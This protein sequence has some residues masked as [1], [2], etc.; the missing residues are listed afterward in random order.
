VAL[1]LDGST[2]DEDD[3]ALREM[4]LAHLLHQGVAFKTDVDRPA[5]LRMA[6]QNGRLSV[7]N[8][9]DGGKLA[10]GEP[11]DILVLDWDAVD[12]ERLREDL[13]PCDLLFARTTMR[14]IHEVIIGGRTVIRDGE[15]LGVDYPAM[16]EELLGRLRATMAQNAA[17]AAALRELERAVASHYQADAPCC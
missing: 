14:H 3:D 11:A 5:M 2:F 17:L 12:A 4:R 9:D 6:F 10:P 13:D 1:G 8:R 15:V 7:T 16:R